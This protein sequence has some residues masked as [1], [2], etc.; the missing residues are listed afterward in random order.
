LPAMSIGPLL[1]P[2]NSISAATASSPTTRFVCF[3]RM[4][5]KA[6]VHPLKYCLVPFLSRIGSGMDQSFQTK[7]SASRLTNMSGSWLSQAAASR[8]RG[9]SRVDLG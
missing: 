7:S 4:S 3:T 1:D 8:S 5:G 2:I 6:V 9:P